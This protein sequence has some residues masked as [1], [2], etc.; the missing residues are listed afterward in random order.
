MRRFTL[1]IHWLLKIC[2]FIFFLLSV[3]IRWDQIE[4]LSFFF[5]FYSIFFF[6]FLKMKSSRTTTNY[7]NIYTIQ[8][9]CCNNIKKQANQKPKER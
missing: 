8:D 1:I 9:D 3:S 7:I 2:D 5:F 4:F 6:F